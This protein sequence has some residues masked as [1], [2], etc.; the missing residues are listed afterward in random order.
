LTFDRHKY[1]KIFNLRKIFNI[2]IKER[3]RQEY[4]N[5]FFICFGGVFSSSSGILFVHL[6]KKQSENLATL[7]GHLPFLRVAHCASG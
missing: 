4:G 6:A 3:A 1:V 5:F 2:N 7:V